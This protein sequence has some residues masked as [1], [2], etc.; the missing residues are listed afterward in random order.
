MTVQC[1]S[2]LPIAAEFFRIRRSWHNIRA[3]TWKTSLRASLKGWV[4]KNHLY[5]KR[6]R[7][8]ITD[9]KLRLPVT[10]QLS[11][12][13]VKDQGDFWDQ[14]VNCSHDNRV[15]EAACT[16]ISSGPKMSIIWAMFSSTKTTASYFQQDHD[17]FG[18][19]KMRLTSSSLR[20]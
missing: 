6:G 18:D 1:L 20:L 2:S 3:R 14:P 7:L 13:V 17:T 9:R 10:L 8:L 16:I 11:R 15:Y 19:P 4:S 5:A 12:P